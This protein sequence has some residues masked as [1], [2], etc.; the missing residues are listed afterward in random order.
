MTF[1]LFRFFSI[2]I[3]AM[4]VFACFGPYRRR[5]LDAQKLRSS[6]LREIALHL[7]VLCLFGLAAMILWPPYHW[8]NSRGLWGDL[9]I[10]TARDSR[11]SQVNLIPLRTITMFLRMLLE[12]K[13]YDPIINLLGNIVTFLPLGFFPA[14]LFRQVQ[15]GKIFLIGLGFSGSCEV[16]QYFI[17]RNCDVDDLLLNLLGV[18]LGFWLCCLFRRLLPGLDR[19]FHCRKK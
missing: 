11:L 16:L 8:E 9:V 17:G 19:V 15:S 4:A 1:H 18:F 13:R 14:L 10:H 2:G 6:F 3:P 7:F 12:G 5:A